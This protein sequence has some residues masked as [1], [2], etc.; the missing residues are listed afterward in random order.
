[1]KCNV[2]PLETGKDVAEVIVRAL[3]QGKEMQITER[4]EEVANV[5]SHR[6]SSCL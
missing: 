4:K 5:S 6:W 2:S 1:M 3:T